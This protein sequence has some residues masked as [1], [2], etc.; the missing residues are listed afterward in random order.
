M[1]SEF[2]ALNV[3][4]ILLVFGRVGGAMLVMPG[5][6]GRYVPTRARLAL[7]MMITIVSL[8]AIATP[9]PPT[10]DSA[11]TLV[12]LLAIE[13]SIG[14]FLGLV[15][16][17][18]LVAINLTGVVMGFASGL[19]MAQAFDPLNAQ[20]GSLI[21]SFLGQVALVSLFALGLHHVMISAVVESYALMPV[22]GLPDTGDMAQLLTGLVSS[23]FRV[24]WQ[25]ASPFVIYG[26][27]FQSTLG[28]IAR[29]MPQLNVLFIAMPAQI[30]FGLSLF[31]LTIPFIMF[32]FLTYF[33]RGMITLS[34]P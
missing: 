3:F 20:Q 1:L 6:S 19:M 29:L 23:G 10:P 13:V 15:G 7:A 18:L 27:I 26:I 31:S 5:F 11:T 24:G 4:Q 32:T 2:L 33:E 34:V 8:P 22:G 17:F 25:L 12:L 14:L 28:I 21:S 9:L 16:Q 30:L